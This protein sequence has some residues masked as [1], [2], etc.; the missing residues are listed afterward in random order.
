MRVSL[1]TRYIDKLTKISFKQLL[2]MISITWT[3]IQ[4]H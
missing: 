4:S 3:K 2:T 1:V